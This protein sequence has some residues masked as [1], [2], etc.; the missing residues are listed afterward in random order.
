MYARVAICLPCANGNGDECCCKKVLLRTISALS[1]ASDCAR[2]EDGV[3]L[4]IMTAV[5]TVSKTSLYATTR[6]LNTPLMPA[7]AGEDCRLIPMFVQAE[8]Q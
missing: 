5:R 4:A 1:N 7:T 2:L 6:L 3:G 8:A